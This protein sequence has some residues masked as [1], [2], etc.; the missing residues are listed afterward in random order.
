[1]VRAA[2]VLV[3]ASRVGG[4][5]AVRFLFPPAPTYAPSPLQWQGPSPLPQRPADT[6]PAGGPK[7]PASARPAHGG[8]FSPA[9]SGAGL[10]CALTCRSTE[11]CRAWAG[12]TQCVSWSRPHRR[13]PF[14]RCNGR[15][16][17]PC[18]SA[19]LIPGQPG[20]QSPRPAP[21]PPPAGASRPPGR[22]LASC[23]VGG[24]GLGG[25]VP[26]G[27]GKRMRFLFPP[28]AAPED[29]T[30]NHQP[31]CN[32]RGHRPCH[33]AT[34][35]PGPPGA[36][37]PRPAP[38]PPPAGASRPPGRALAFVA[39]GPAGLR[40]TVPRRRGKR[41][42][43]PVPAQRGNPF[44]GSGRY[45]RQAVGLLF[46]HPVRASADHDSARST[47]RTAGFL[48]NATHHMHGMP[49]KRARCRGLPDWQTGQSP[50]ACCGGRPRICAVYGRAPCPTV[51][52]C[53][54]GRSAT[55]FL[56]PMIRAIGAGA[57]GAGAA[58]GGDECVNA[59]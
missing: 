14:H 48:C 4:G 50:E 53:P 43:F 21:A 27:R 5:N 55:P 54:A 18:H 42:A 22:A 1:L 25:S 31:R 45:S 38:A 9:G 7:P 44:P 32:G 58:V 2:R 13:K 37:S 11:N 36:Q 39:P 35:I 49:P 30:P 47:A 59:R 40:G 17:R 28:G 23:C 19:R 8:R 52:A 12:E 26:R 24:T 46:Q 51:P 41:S 10:R 15:G 16:H 20:A 34:L 6:W 57:G 29:Q 56:P 3:E 33:G